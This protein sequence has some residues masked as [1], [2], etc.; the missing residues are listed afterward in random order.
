MNWPESSDTPWASYQ[1]WRDVLLNVV[2]AKT[3][4]LG[5]LPPLS[6][7]PKVKSFVS[8]GGVDYIPPSGTKNLA[9]AGFLPPPSPPLTVVFFSFFHD[10]L[11]FRVYIFWFFCLTNV[12][13]FKLF[14]Y[15]WYFFLVVLVLDIFLGAFST[16]CLLLF[17]CLFWFLYLVTTL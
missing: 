7:T 17:C 14:L 4:P 5:T 8:N 15:F 6:Q 12:I 10:S 2:I 9:S 11:G 13:R 1:I 3:A 16:V